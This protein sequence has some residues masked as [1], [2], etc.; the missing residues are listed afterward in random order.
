MI[1]E[2]WYSICCTAPPMY[3]LHIDDGIEPAG[4][5]MQCRD[6]A[7]FELMKEEEDE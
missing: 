7:T 3:D 2:E 5:C 1:E 6:H 4:L